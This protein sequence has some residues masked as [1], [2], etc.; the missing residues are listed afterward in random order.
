MQIGNSVKLQTLAPQKSKSQNFS[1]G[2]SYPMLL[3]LV[4]DPPVV[5]LHARAGLLHQ[6]TAVGHAMIGMKGAQ[7]WAKTKELAGDTTEEDLLRRQQAYDDEGPTPH[8]GNGREERHR[9]C[10][11]L[12]CTDREILASERERNHAKGG[13]AIELMFCKLPLHPSGPVSLSCTTSANTPIS[14][15]LL[16]TVTFNRMSFIFRYRGLC[17]QKVD[18]PIN[19]GY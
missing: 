8:W 16:A 3:T 19:F 18:D 9:L 1:R 6:V 5:L 10:F 14:L 11:T 2:S 15:A 17:I 13:V 12:W 4:V 7:H